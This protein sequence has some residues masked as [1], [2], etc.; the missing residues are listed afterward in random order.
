MMGYAVPGYE[1]VYGMI[2]RL[3]FGLVGMLDLI[4]GAIVIISAIR[5]NQK[6][7]EHMVWVQ[8]QLLHLPR[9]V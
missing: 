4:F 2:S 1:Y 5:L 3:G 8:N 7:Q 9:L 6:P